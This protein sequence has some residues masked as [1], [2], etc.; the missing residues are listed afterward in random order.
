MLAMI[1]N[2]AFT[3]Q[4]LFRKKHLMFGFLRNG[5]SSTE[6]K[7]AHQSH[8]DCLSITEFGQAFRLGITLLPRYG[9]GNKVIICTICSS[10]LAQLFFGMYNSMYQA[11][12]TVNLHRQVGNRYFV[13]ASNAARIYF[14]ADAAVAFFEVHWER[15]W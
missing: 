4:L 15:L 2:L 13:S 5:L 11:C 12:S 7:R 14:L 8:S 6:S 9:S 1:Q 10:F 3:I